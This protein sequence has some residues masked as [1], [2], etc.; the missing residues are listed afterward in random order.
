MVY[1]IFVGH[2]LRQAACHA[3]RGGCLGPG[4][5]ARKSNLGFLHAAVLVWYR[6]DLAGGPMAR[7]AGV[8]DRSKTETGRGGRLRRGGRGVYGTQGGHGGAGNPNAGDFRRLITMLNRIRKSLDSLVHIQPAIVPQVLHSQFVST[9]PGVDR[10][11]KR[12]IRHLS[13]KPGPVL[14]QQLREAGLRERCCG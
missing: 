5:L 9:W 1:A 10:Q 8:L 14:L 3:L 12:A 4:L 13:R 6:R 2:A 7:N 11:F